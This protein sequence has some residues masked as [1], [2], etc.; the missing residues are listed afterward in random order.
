MYVVL[1]ILQVLAVV[2]CMF[3]IVLLLLQRNT[4]QSK[5]MLLTI[6]CAFIQNFGYLLELMA[7]TLGEAMIAVKIEY[8]GTAYIAYFLT[9]FMF[10]YSNINFPRKYSW[11]WFGFSST[12]LLAVLFYQYNSFY[13]TST[14]FVH[15]GLFPHIV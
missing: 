5:M 15:T 14:E 6:V 7:T 3:S 11:I 2:I 12:V 1:V 10:R 9:F 4:K 8:V 13:Y